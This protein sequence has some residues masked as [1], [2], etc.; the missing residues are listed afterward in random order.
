MTAIELNRALQTE[1]DSLYNYEGLTEK[2]LSYIRKMKSQY[3]QQR[4]SK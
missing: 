2:V 1:V 4:I 3:D